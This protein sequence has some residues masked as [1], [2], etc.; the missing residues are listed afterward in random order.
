LGSALG[1]KTNCASKIDATRTSIPLS[2]ITMTPPRRRWFAFSLRTMFVGVVLIAA[3]LA[4]VRHQLDWIEE[5]HQEFLWEEGDLGDAP[6]PWHLW[7]FGERYGVEGMSIGVTDPD[8]GAPEERER[9]QRLFPEAR[10]VYR[11]VRHI[12]AEPAE[13]DKPPQ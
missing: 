2:D 8:V 1:I 5:R 7:I 13:R 10:V 4:L 6:P 9:M 12:T 11:K 3:S